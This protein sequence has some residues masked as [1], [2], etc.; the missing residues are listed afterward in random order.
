MQ[1]LVVTLQFLLKGAQNAQ[2]SFPI[3]SQDFR[4]FESSYL[5]NAS[6]Y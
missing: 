4:D 6:R 1:I 5:W 2:L 3:F